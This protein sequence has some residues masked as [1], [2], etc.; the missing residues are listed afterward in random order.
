MC[1][2][3]VA[4]RQ[5]PVYD[6]IVAAN[7]DEFYQRPSAAAR[8]W[9]Q[10]PQVLAGR[11]ETAG[12]TWLGI[13]QR[14]YFAAVTNLRGGGGARDGYSRGHLVRDFLLQEDT[15]A[16]FART[17]TPQGAHYAGCNLLLA[18]RE[19]LWWWSN[20]TNRE[21][22]A[23]VY[24]VSNSPLDD[25]W[26]KVERLKAAFEPLRPLHGE[27][28]LTA[29]LEVLRDAPATHASPGDLLSTRLEDTIFV[30]TPAY[31]TRCTSIVLRNPETRQLAFVERRFTPGAEIAGESR[32]VVDSLS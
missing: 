14:G 31:G 22:P 26:P 30:H 10:H 15:A 11:D 18:D 24:G 17:L 4:Y 6:L 25:E 13:N 23:G 8:F 20:D 28:L 29:L 1:I 32:F 5:H 7:R 27:P 21:L 9:P 16:Q 2:L 3:L 12:G 19:R